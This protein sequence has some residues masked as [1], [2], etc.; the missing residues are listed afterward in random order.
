MLTIAIMILILPLILIYSFK[1]EL[2]YQCPLTFT[3][4]PGQMLSERPRKGY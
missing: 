1:N 3:R 2:S 4:K